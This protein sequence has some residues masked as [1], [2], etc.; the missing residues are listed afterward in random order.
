MNARAL[1][2]DNAQRPELVR[3]YVWEW[4]VRLTHWL[5]VFSL[6]VLVCTGLY[7]GHPFLSSP[8]P[9]EERF[10][11]GTAKVVHSYAAII[12]TLSVLVRIIWMFTGNRYAS[13]RELIPV[14]RRRRRG[15]LPTLAFY[16]FLRRDPPTFVG[17]NPLAG[18]TYSI[19]FLLYFTM[20]ATGFA[21]YSVGA[22]VDSHMRVFAALLPLFGGAQGA[23]WIHHVGMW[24]LL[25]FAVHHVYSA[26]MMAM[27]EKKGTLESIVS[28]YKFFTRSDL[29]ATPSATTRRRK[30]GS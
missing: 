28:G 3:T 14:P 4:P 10:V 26:V 7:I 5:I 21:L 27:V 24:L 9:S 30:D 25:G 17:H 16:L 15:L 13:W 12:F 6:A 11:M 20:I 1:T 2:A 23:R 22:P 8:G 19:V 29:R 18:A